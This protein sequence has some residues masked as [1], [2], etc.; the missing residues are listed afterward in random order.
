M[1]HG[2][3]ELAAGLRGLIARADVTPAEVSRR[4]EVAEST[5]S[6]WIGGKVAVTPDTVRRILAACDARADHAAEGLEAAA[7]EIAAGSASRVVILRSG[8]ATSQRRWGKLEETAEHVATFTTLIVPGLLQTEAYIRALFAS[9]GREGETLEGG[10]RGRMR[11]QTAM[12]ISSTRYTQIT[13]EGALRWRFGSRELMLEQAEH[14]AAAARAETGPRVRIGFI[15][16]T[17]PTNLIP[18]TSFDLYDS[19]T[20]VVGSSFG[21]AFMDRP[22]DVAVYVEQLEQLERL[23]V[24]GLEAAAEFERIAQDYRE[25]S[26]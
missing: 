25:K 8:A 22:Q 14:L 5:V 24:F 11:R 7:E 19:S 20:A 13:T 16:W 10:V 4:L 23:A 21:T 26:R 18:M 6:R 2:R 3:H 12:L 1:T 17:V 15:P 9:G